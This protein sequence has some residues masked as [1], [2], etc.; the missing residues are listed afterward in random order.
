MSSDRKIEANRQNAKLSTGP[1][2]E[3]GKAASSQNARKHGLSGRALYVPEDRQEEFASLQAALH[4]ELGPIG[5]IQ[6]NYFEQ[7]LFA[8]WNLTIARELYSAA[9]SCFDEK[10]M[11]TFARFI[12]QFERSFQRAH[13][14]IQDEQ[15]DLALRAIPENEA[16]ENLPAC[17]KIKVIANEATRIARLQER[18]HQRDRRAAILDVIGHVFR[19]DHTEED[20]P[21]AA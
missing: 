3:E 20:L 18:S 5:E 6:T 9:I 12:S 16:I 2:T 1:K 17:C 10:R 11:A 8:A 4:A 13:R 19:P 21:Q 15:T 14:A 7:L